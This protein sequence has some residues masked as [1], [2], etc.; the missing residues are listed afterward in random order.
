MIEYVFIGVGLYGAFV[1]LLFL[2]QRRFIYLPDRNVPDIAKAPW[3]KLITITTSDNLRL[4]GWWAEPEAETSPVIAFFH[5]NADNIEDR[6]S[7]A[8]PYLSKGYG[9]LLAEYRGYGGNPGSPSEEGLYRDARAYLDWLLNEQAVTADWLIIYGESLGSGVATQMATE[10]ASKALVLDV[11]FFSVLGMCKFR[12][13]MIPFMHM[14]VKDHFRSDLKIGRIKRPVFIGV[15]ERDFIIPARFGK[16]LF[17]AAQEPKQFKSYPGAGHL[18][19]Y[20]Q[21]FAADVI[22]FIENLNSVE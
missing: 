6:I 10:Y 13:P 14:L 4:N 12:F 7:K 21:G 15:G 22:K 3:A 16:K 2:T 19:I 17:D 11:P 20:E 1:L 8:E 5:G 9:V 18:G